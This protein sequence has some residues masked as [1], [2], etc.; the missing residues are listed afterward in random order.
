MN[1]V[2]KE[3][4]VYFQSSD[5]SFPAY[6]HVETY[7]PGCLSRHDFTVEVFQKPDGT[8]YSPWSDGRSLP[9]WG[10]DGNLESPTFTPS[11]LA[12]F[13]VHL[14]PEEYVHVEECAQEECSHGGHG[15][16]WRLADG[17]IY[18]YKID[19][20]K[21]EDAT[22]IHITH[23]P[24]IVEPAFGNCHSFLRNGQ[25]EFLGDSAHHLA[26]QKVPMIPLPDWI[27]R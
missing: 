27:M 8:P 19:E 9:V 14:C 13:T 12:Y 21:P 24:H 1:P 18:S 17:S 26:N 16:A 23:L 25:W 5:G 22:E 10:W 11:M 4:V 3:S 6:R 7:C 20:V 15:L 2:A